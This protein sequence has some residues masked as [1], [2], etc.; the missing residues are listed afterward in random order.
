MI[1][2]SALPELSLYIHLPWCVRKCPYCDFNS[3]EQQA[4]L[5]ERAYVEALV[6]DLEASLPLIW[7]RPVISIFIG[8]GT[9]SLFSPEMIGLLISEVR[10][11]LMLLPDVEITMEANPGTFEVDRF[12]GFREA[13][14]N[15]LSVGVQSFDVNKLKVLGRI[16]DA[17]Q[18]RAALVHAVQIFDRVNADLM[19]GLPG[20]TLTELE[21]ELSELVQLGLSHVSCYQLTMEPNTRFGIRPPQGLPDDDVLADMQSLVI[22]R[23]RQAGLSRYEISAFSRAGQE[24]RHNLNYWTFGDYLGIGAGAHG[25][26][27]FADRILRTEK[28]RNPKAY[29]EGGNDAHGEPISIESLPFEFMLNALRLTAGVP[30]SRWSQTTG[31][32]VGEHPFLL[33]R[34]GQAQARGL[35]RADAGR[36]QATDRGLEL[37]NDLQALFLP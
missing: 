21:R 20:Q 35:M 23:L 29:M 1:R 25:K 15:R 16:H 12:R 26:I 9:P 13:G 3:H 8:G 17:D 6:R 10:A 2:F 7:G 32:S 28:L 14:V 5:P 27:S 36:F 11:R 19:F 37:L 22:H 4:E 24:C 33:E 18:A 30:A 34:L 31:M